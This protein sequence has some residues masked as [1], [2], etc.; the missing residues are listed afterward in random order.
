MHIHEGVGVYDMHRPNKNCMRATN[1]NRTGDLILT[2]DAH[3]RLCYI[4]IPSTRG[5]RRSS[6]N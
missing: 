2:K 3:Y 1:Q 5:V 6:T 4:S